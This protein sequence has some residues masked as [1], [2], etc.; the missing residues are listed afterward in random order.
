[1]H[2]IHN[3][4]LTQV[5][6]HKRFKCAC[7]Q[8]F[9][10]GSGSDLTRPSCKYINQPWGINKLYCGYADYLFL[11]HCGIEK[12]DKNCSNLHTFLSHNASEKD[13]QCINN[14]AC[15]ILN[16]IVLVVVSTTKHT[17][18]WQKLVFYTCTFY[19]YFMTHKLTLE[20]NSKTF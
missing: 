13:N 7:G 20:A 6:H 17:T 11:M 19:F 12:G 18:I 5:G 3:R 8:G 15:L 4:P 16:H 2:V 10:V 14:K 1:M 9:S